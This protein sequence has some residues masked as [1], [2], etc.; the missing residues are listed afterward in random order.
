MANKT[1]LVKQIIPW[2]CSNENF[3]N[4]KDGAIKWRV[5]AKIMIA[6]VILLLGKQIFLKS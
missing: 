6:M 1:D 2:T 5:N 4:C 3:I